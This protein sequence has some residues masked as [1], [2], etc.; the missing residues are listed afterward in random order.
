MRRVACKLTDW[1]IWLEAIP[2]EERELYEYAAYN[3]FITISPLML[4][5]LFGIFMGHLMESIML[6]TPFMIIRKFSGGY[7]MKNST[8]CFL[9][10][11]FI[12]IVC[13]ILS[14]KLKY[15]MK[16]GIVVLLS[17]VSLITFSPLDSQNRR[18]DEE[19]KRQYKKMTC[20]FTMV[21]VALFFLLAYIEQYRF[22]TCIAVGIALTSVLQIPCILRDIKYKATKKV[23]KM[24]FHI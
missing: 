22:A 16:M 11:C 5:I 10:S 3:F 17:S 6:V 18:L 20:I 1:L 21:F 14:C 15:D 4:A 13:I 2:K 7:H 9:T 23:A 12:L 8:S 19:E 24:S